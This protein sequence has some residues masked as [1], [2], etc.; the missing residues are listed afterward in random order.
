MWSEETYTPLAYFSS[1][2]LAEHNETIQHLSNLQ[3]DII[4]RRTEL[5]SADRDCTID[6]ET[7]AAALSDEEAQIRLALERNEATQEKFRI[8]RENDEAALLDDMKDIQ[9]EQE[10]VAEQVRS[11][12]Q[13]EADLRRMQLEMTERYQSLADRRKEFIRRFE[14]AA[15]DIESVRQ[16]TR[17]VGAEVH[18]L[19]EVHSARSVQHVRATSPLREARALAGVSNQM[20]SSSAYRNNSNNNNNSAFLPEIFQRATNSN[21]S[22][23]AGLNNSR[24]T[25]SPGRRSS[26]SFLG[27]ESAINSQNG[28][29]NFNN[30]TSAG[31]YAPR[32]PG[33]SPRPTIDRPGV[34]PTRPGRSN[35]FG[36][37]SVAMPPAQGRL[38][39]LCASGDVDAALRLLKDFPSEVNTIDAGG[40]TPLHAACASSVVSL[41]L[42]TALLLAGA[43][44]SGKNDDGL[45]PFHIACLNTS[46]HGQL[47]GHR[48]KRHL[49][50][51]AAVSPN[52]R[53]A[54]GETAAHLCATNDRHLDALRFLVGS[55]MDLEIKAVSPSPMDP[56]GSNSR[57]V[58]ARE[59]ASRCGSAKIVEFLEAIPR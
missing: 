17:N 36:S 28:N 40:N 54:R 3:D 4:R 8:S 29:N 43:S 49:I 7:R 24:R 42:V 56:E 27:D 15:Q 31:S 25:L 59:K 52:Q 34:S 21:G 13:A 33:A 41:P 58:T 19:E 45:T 2:T 47:T 10:G 48:L 51:K 20:N 53:T 22:G 38:V 9:N 30:Y 11:L 5:L 37:S 35:T 44:T 57:A 16:N 26:V 18:K 14:A 32:P 39:S 23:N 46:D 6:H 50:F 55:G 1:L 12:D